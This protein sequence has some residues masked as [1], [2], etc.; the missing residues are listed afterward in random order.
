M[1]SVS[2]LTLIE[3]SEPL[4]VAHTTLLEISYR[5]SN[6]VRNAFNFYM[7]RFFFGPVYVN[8]AAIWLA[9]LGHRVGL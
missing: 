8:D 7:G 4:L 3:S 2:S 5:G 1:C 6:F 9:P